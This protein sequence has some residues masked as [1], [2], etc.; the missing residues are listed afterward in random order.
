H[1]DL[2]MARRNHYERKTKDLFDDIGLEG[3]SYRN[4]S[5]RKQQLMTALKELKGVHLTTG[6]ITT[7][8]LERTKDDKDYKLIIRKSGRMPLPVVEHAHDAITSGGD[9]ASHTEPAATNTACIV[10]AK[11]LV[12]HFSKRFHNTETNY[13]TSKA[14]NQA[15]ALIAQHGVDQARHIIDFAY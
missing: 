12:N 14:I 2:I 3:S 15:I 13:P 11:E 10:Q 6:V 4:P 7:A 9:V 8:T 1:L 5:N